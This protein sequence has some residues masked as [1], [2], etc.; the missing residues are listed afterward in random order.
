MLSRQSG[1]DTVR[2]SIFPNSRSKTILAGGAGEAQPHR[3]VLF[4][5]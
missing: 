1:Q 5:D 4:V 2:L 3:L